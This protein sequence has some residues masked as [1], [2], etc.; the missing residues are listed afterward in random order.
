MIHFN[1]IL[2]LRV[3]L[4]SGVFPSGFSTKTYIPIHLI[5]F[6]LIFLIIF[7]EEYS[8]WSPSLCSF[9]QPPIISPLFSPNIHLS[10]LCWNAFCLCSSLNVRNQ[11]SHPSKTAGKIIVLDILIFTFLHLQQIEQIKNLLWCCSPSE[12]LGFY[13]HLW[14]GSMLIIWSGSYQS[15][16]V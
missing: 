16:W 6:D 10:I 5:F 14:A 7:G 2:H 12:L 15:P 8:L 9:L 11:V 4:R 1:I 13:G 3:G